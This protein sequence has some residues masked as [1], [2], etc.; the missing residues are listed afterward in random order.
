M[1][2]PDTQQADG[3][4]GGV[5]WW[6]GICL[7]V[8]ALYPVSAGPVYW[9]TYHTSGSVALPDVYRPLVPVARELGVSDIL[10]WWLTLG[11]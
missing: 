9:Y 11:I 1:P 2:E 3:K 10:W 5:L 8:V 4:R 6:A 7:A